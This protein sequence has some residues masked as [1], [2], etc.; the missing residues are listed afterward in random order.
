MR[1]SATPLLSGKYGGDR[2]NWI[3]A[4]EKNIF[5]YEDPVISPARAAIEVAQGGSSRVS[6]D[7]MYALIGA[8]FSLP[9]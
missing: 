6:A 8:L 4:E 5:V 1:R 3:M 7:E 2:S 9:V